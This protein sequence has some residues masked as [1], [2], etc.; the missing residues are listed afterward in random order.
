MALPLLYGRVK[1]AL[2]KKMSIFSVH[3]LPDAFLFY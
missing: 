1:I 2:Q 3:G